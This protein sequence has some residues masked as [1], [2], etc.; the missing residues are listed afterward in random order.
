[1]QN[2]EYIRNNSQEFDLKLAKR[3]IAKQSENI[4]SL[5]LQVRKHKAKLQELQQQKNYI[6][7]NIGQKKSKGEDASQLFKQAEEVKQSIHTLENNNI[8]YEQLDKLLNSLPNLL[9]N[10]VDRKSHV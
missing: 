10:D 6:A 1:M 9:D 3:E 2:I 4:L 8:E 5:D 7:K